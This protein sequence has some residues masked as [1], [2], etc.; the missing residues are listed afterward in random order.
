MRLRVARRAE[1]QIETIAAWWAENRHA[2]PALFLDELDYTFR[3]ICD[4]PGV[5]VPWPTVR[6]PELRR[7]LLPRTRYHVYFRADKIA[8]VVYVMAVWGAPR[9]RTPKL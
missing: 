5:G 9:G 2:A 1:R 3:L 7:V 6:R 4:A 8:D